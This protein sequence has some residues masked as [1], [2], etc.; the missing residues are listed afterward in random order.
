MKVINKKRL[1]SAKSM[2]TILLFF[3]LVRSAAGG[4]PPG[5]KRGRWQTLLN[6][7][8]VVAMHTALTHRNTVMIFDQT[9]AGR[10]GYPLRRSHYDG[11]RCVPSSWNPSVDSSCW[12]HSVEYDIEGNTIRALN[13]ETD[14]WCSSGTFLSN[15]TLLQTGGHGHGYRRIRYFDPCTDHRCDWRSPEA[16]LLADNR[17]Y[18]S[19][20]ILP[21]K[22]RV[23]IVGGR[24]VFTYE[25]LPKLLSSSSSSRERSF[26]LSLLRQTNNRKEEGN[27]LYPFLHL[28]SDG[29]L[30]IF[31][32]RDSILLDYWRNKVV[33]TFPRMPGGGSRNYPSS[34]SSVLIPLDHTDGFQKVE[35]MVCGGATTGAY[36]AAKRKTYLK[37]LSSCGRIVIT[38]QK[39]RWEMEEM[40]GPRLLHDILILPTGN[41]LIINGATHGCAGWNNA[42]NPSLEPYLYKPNKSL[43]R[44]FSV[45]KSTKVARLYHSSAILLPDGRVLVAGSNPHA[46]YTFKDV[47]FPTELRLQAFIPYYMDQYFDGRRPNNLSI[48]YSNGGYGA[49]YREEFTIKF[50]L[51]L[52]REPDKDSIKFSAYSPPFTT[53]GV[54]MNQRM[55][56]LKCKSIVREDGGW[57]RAVVEAPP[58]PNVAPSGY[59][60][61]TVI[62]GG[63]PSI[64]QWVRFMQEN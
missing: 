36:T 16:L 17:W 63:I 19:N 27:N 42:A 59:Y 25:F 61:L 33:K 50:R 38:E 23:I 5:A 28:S 54:S 62:N 26:Y 58:S 49:R 43:G 53:H 10:S 1:F 9:R 31:A 15:G 44:R 8:G 57:M 6:N 39:P 32:N 55:L 30:F 64:A 2:P 34:G 29:N 21:E 46:R 37:G 24:R 40:P 13:L 18:A 48:H 56:R 60:L 22:D 52:Q 11:S 4:P 35:V 47:K 45:L 7:T 41:I 3:L 20:Q 51:D 12:A 14:T